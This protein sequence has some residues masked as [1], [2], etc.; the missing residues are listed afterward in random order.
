VDPLLPKKKP[1]P[2][3]REG[4]R[5]TRKLEIVF[6]DLAGPQAV[7]AQGGYLY[8]L[9]LIDDY[10]HNQWTI[11]LKNKSDAAQQMIEWQAIVEAES[12][13]K[14]NMGLRSKLRHRIPPHK[15]GSSNAHI[16]H[17]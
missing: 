7:A 5:A 6:G 3:K 14:A 11:L 2:K 16:I 13:E 1:V 9:Q 10:T 15:S 8:T 12:G 17:S 4:P